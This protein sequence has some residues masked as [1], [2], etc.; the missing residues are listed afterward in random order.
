LA[1]SLLLGWLSDGLQSLNVERRD[2]SCWFELKY[3]P[4][5]SDYIVAAMSELDRGEKLRSR[6]ALPAER[7]RSVIFLVESHQFDNGASWDDEEEW[8]FAWPILLVQSFDIAVY[9]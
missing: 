9:R 7:P 2:C 8:F 5:Y 6:R 1:V 4:R 3:L